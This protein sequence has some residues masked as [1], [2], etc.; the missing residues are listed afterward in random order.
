MKA[1]AYRRSLPIADPQCLLDVV[2]P[3]PVAQGRD[4][5]VKVEAIK[6]QGDRKGER[7]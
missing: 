1:V 7:K 2:L 4:L 6:A 3:A 5:L